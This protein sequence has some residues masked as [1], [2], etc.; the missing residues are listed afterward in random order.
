M[1]TIKTTGFV[2]WMLI[3][4][5]P[6]AA[7]ADQVANHYFLG[8]NEKQQIID[9][10]FKFYQHTFPEIV[11]A[12]AT[13]GEQWRDDYI[14]ITALLGEAPVDQDYEHPPELRGNVMEVSLQRLALMLQRN[15]ISETLFRTDARG[16]LKGQPLCVI[17][18]NPKTYVADNLETTSYMVDLPEE[19]IKKIHPS[20]LLDPRDHL[21]FTIDHEIYHCLDSHFTGGAPMTMK[22]FGGDFNQFRRESGAD[23]FALAMHYRYA[24]NTPRYAENMTMYR[25]LWLFS[26]GPNR[27]TFESML[28]IYHL[29]ATALS[30]K[31]VMEIFRLATRVRDKNAGTYEFYVGRLAAKLKAAKQLGYDPSVNDRHL[32]SL[33]EQATDPKRVAYKVN[34]YQYYYA[35]LFDDLPIDFQPADPSE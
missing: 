4:L 22:E 18:L 20:R 35:R 15:I 11:F 5:L 30:G 7:S 28:E 19:L 27:C 1:Y 34:R 2:P 16:P 32:A 12:H 24:D 17:T 23:A 25:A 13:G 3:L 21:R 29:P 10:R 26:E 14:A 31:T 9:E 8:N 33:Y 6:V